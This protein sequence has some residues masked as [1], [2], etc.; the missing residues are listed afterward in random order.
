[1]NFS[2]SL[3]CANQLTLLEEI[4]NLESTGISSFHVDIM[5]GIFVKNFALSWGQVQA[6]RKVTSLPLEVHMMVKD[7]QPHKEFIVSSNVD[8]VFLHSNPKNLKEDIDFLKDNGIVP[9]IVVDK[10]VSLGDFDHLK[11]VSSYFLYMRVKPGFAG[12]KPLP[13]CDKKLKQLLTENPEVKIAVDGAVSKEFVKT[14]SIYPNCNYVL[15]T[16]ALFNRGKNY[17]ELVNE[18]ST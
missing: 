15:G 16:S 8:V 18:L 13:G 6:I 14:F 2:P 3:M 7:L 4:E 12:Q 11:K 9:G 17:R 10:D 1:M 5:D